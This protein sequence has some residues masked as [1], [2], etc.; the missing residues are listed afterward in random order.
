[1]L[2]HYLFDFLLLLWLR[3]CLRLFSSCGLWWYLH[4]FNRWLLFVF[5]L[6]SYCGLLSSFLHRYYWKR[7]NW[8]TIRLVVVVIRWLNELLTFFVL[9]FT[10][11]QETVC[12][13]TPTLLLLSNIVL[14]CGLS[15]QGWELAA[16]YHFLALICR[17]LDPDIL[18]GPL[19]SLLIY[20]LY[21]A[22][23]TI[24][25]FFVCFWWWGRFLI[26]VV[27]AEVSLI[28]QFHHFSSFN[29]RWIWLTRLN[30]LLVLFD[31]FGKKYRPGYL[32]S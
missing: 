19:Q 16:C 5:A 1:M 17:D 3:F 32:P 8:L 7:Q 9:C 30:V 10:Q 18:R 14:D 12:R 28:D 13:L 2:L 26:C 6:R 27:R 29:F 23:T 25:L 22:F 24:L 4:F 21:E 20:L 31:A 11:V 15:P